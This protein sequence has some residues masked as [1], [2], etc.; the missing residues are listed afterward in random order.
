MV[1]TVLSRGDRSLGAIIEHV[2]RSGAILEAWREHFS[3]DNWAQAFVTEGRDLLT[4][5]GR[6]WHPSSPLPWEHIDSGVS[7]DFL[8]RE[9]AR[10]D[11]A[12]VTEDC[13]TGACQRCGLND[14]M[15]P[16]PMIAGEGAPA[17]AAQ[18]ARTEEYA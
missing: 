9:A 8:R 1:E 13:R 17:A 12:I 7:V 10:A 3:F 14:F 5:A 6:P 11:K 2:Y 15:A 18:A 4:E 16:C